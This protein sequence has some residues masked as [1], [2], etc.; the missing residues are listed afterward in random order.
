MKAPLC[1][2]W[3]EAA[4]RHRPGAAEGEQNGALVLFLIRDLGT[5]NLLP[6]F[7]LFLLFPLGVG[8][9]MID[10]PGER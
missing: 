3:A 1:C 6:S 5:C 10:S 2:R 9:H 7:S 4:D 8:G